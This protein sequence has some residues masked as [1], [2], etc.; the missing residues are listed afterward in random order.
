MDA[1][2]PGGVEVHVYYESMTQ[3]SGRRAAS[4]KLRTRENLWV[5]PKPLARGR[6]LTL[7]SSCRGWMAAA[8]SIAEQDERR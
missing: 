6:P 3:R 1:L 5:F 7:G 4:E 2:E 8:F